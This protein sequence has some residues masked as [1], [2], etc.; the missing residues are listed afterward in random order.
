MLLCS[1]YILLD[2]GGSAEAANNGVVTVR[3]AKAS[4]ISTVE[5]SA[6]WSL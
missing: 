1:F 5:S 2:Y 6:E 4:D 3:T